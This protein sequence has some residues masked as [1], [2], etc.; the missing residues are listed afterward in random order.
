MDS[1]ADEVYEYGAY[2][3][4]RYFQEPSVPWSKNGCGDP[5]IF[6]GIPQ[7]IGIY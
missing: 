7:L 1:K 2:L 6:N 3:L 5:T 4:T